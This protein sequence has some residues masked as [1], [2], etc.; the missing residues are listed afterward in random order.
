[1]ISA[2]RTTKSPKGFTLLE[3]VIVLAISAIVIGGAIGLVIFSGDERTLRS[4]T[5][6]IELM[7]KRARTIAI[8]KQTP[9]A[10]EFR[11]GVVRMMPLAQAGQSE[12]PESRL[13]ESE[14]GS[15]TNFADKKREYVLDPSLSVFFRHWNTEKWLTTVKNDVHVWRFDPDGLCEPIS[16]R[17][18]LDNSSAENTYHP[19]TAT[20]VK[21][22][23]ISEIR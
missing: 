5:G 8:L 17:L 14:A 1:M 11:E 7:A 20:A 23:S 3:I 19:L 6:E 15:E 4:A 21:E 2:V 22:E 9:Y 12:K 16:L 13:A 18:V 10:L